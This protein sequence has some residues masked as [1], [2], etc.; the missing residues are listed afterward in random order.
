[1][2]KHTACSVIQV[3]SDS[4]VTLWTVACQAPLSRR[5]SRQEYES[6]LPF[7]TPGDLPD[8]ETEPASP[9]LSGRFFTSEPLGSLEHT[10]KIKKKKKKNLCPEALP[11]NS[12]LY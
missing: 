8:P 10:Q 2:V 5:F 6:G 1:M 4:F 9:A 7:P 11:S 3:M 12:N